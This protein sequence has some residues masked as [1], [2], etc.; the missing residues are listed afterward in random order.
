[1]TVNP[2]AYYSIHQARARIHLEWTIIRQAERQGR[3]D[4]PR[5][6]EARENIRKLEGMIHEYA[7]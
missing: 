2:A 5:A 7:A 6:V 1:M 4:H 3:P